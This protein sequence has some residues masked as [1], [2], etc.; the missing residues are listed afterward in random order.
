MAFDGAAK[1][2]VRIESVCFHGAHEVRRHRV[3]GERRAIQHEDAV[4]APRQEH[5]RG[6]A[7]ATRTDHD[8]VILYLLRHGKAD[9]YGSKPDEARQLTEPGRAAVR[10]A[11]PIWMR[12][13]IKPD[14]V[15]T[16]PRQRAIDTA[17]LFIAGIGSSAPVGTDDRLAP[18]ARWEDVAKVI[19]AHSGAASILLVGHEPD[20]SD[21]AEHLTGASS[22]KLREGGLCRI[23]FSGA[24]A[25]TAGELTL[26][27]DPDVYAAD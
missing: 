2:S 18:G 19:D 4:A 20:L 14:V 7:G 17:A 27:L 5:R 11:G 8:R 16:S 22:V 21:I 15:I 12:L 26:L 1:V 6:R 23:E 3:A 9:P 10:A 24:P 25:P 13:G